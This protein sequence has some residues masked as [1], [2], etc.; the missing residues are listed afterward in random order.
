MVYKV[1]QGHRPDRPS[2]GFS[3]TLWELL[4]RTWDTESGP[5][6]CV[7]P[8]ASIVRGKLQEDVREWGKSTLPLSPW[9][10][11]SG[12]PEC[13]T[14]A[15]VSLRSPQRQTLMKQALGQG[16]LVSNSRGWIGHPIVD[17]R[18]YTRFRH[19][20]LA[21]APRLSPPDQD[22]P[23]QRRSSRLSRLFSRR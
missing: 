1:T 11:D 14:H 12:Y 6:T 2:P 5:E 10:E 9:Q 7:R 17:T 23:I 15:V 21:P 3:D 4:V 16:S 8:S 18:Y 13:R 20:A 22:N 19:A